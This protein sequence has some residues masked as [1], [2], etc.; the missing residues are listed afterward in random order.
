M[1][2]YLE[3]Y[4]DIEKRIYW[5]QESPRLFFFTFLLCEMRMRQ[6]IKNFKITSFIISCDENYPILVKI[7]LG[8]IRLRV[9]RSIE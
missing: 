6:I 5:V 1:F 7:N 2:E 3:A 8:L 4:F 9:H